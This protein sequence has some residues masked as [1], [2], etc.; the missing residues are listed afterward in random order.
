M[1]SSLRIRKLLISNRGEIACRIIRTARRMNIKTVA[2][3]SSADRNSIHPDLADEAYFIGDPE[4]QKS[5]LNQH[6]IL[7]VARTAHCS[8]IHPGYGFL[9]ENH[10]F[11]SACERDGF[12]FVGPSAQ[13]IKSMGLKSESKQI[14]INAGVPVVPGYHGDGQSN[15]CLMEAAKSIGYPIMLKPVRGGGG[16]G[17]RII[18]SES[19]FIEALESSRRES[20]KSFNDDSMLLERYIVN[21]RHIEVQIFGDKYRNHV[22][23]F[24]RDCSIQRRHQKIIE[25][26]PA[27]MI[28][29]K[30]RQHIGQLAVRAAKAVD[31]VGAGT[32][33]FIMDRDTDELFFMEMNTRLQVE[34]PITEE[35]TNTDLVEWQL[36]VA[37][38]ERLPKNQSEINRSGH[39][40]EA[41]IYAEDPSG[42]FLPEIGTLEHVS[43]PDIDVVSANGRVRVDTG[44]STGAIISP[45][46][47]PMIA[48]L[49][50]WHETRD[51]ALRLLRSC[52][53]RYCIS[54][55]STN[56]EFLSKVAGNHDFELG[57]FGTD[58]LVRHPEI[59]DAY[60]KADN[61]N[62]SDTKHL[63]SREKLP[64]I[65]AAVAKLFES[66]SLEKFC[67]NSFRTIGIPKPVHKLTI[68]E[69][70]LGEFQ[71]SVQLDD[72]QRMM[73]QVVT[74]FNDRKDESS[75]EHVSWWSQDVDRRQLIVELNSERRFK[76]E[77]ILLPG[78]NEALA[79]SI[80]VLVVDKSAN[81]DDPSSR[82]LRFCF[83]FK[84]YMSSDTQSQHQH[85]SS[86]SS[87]SPM[88][89]LVEKILIKVGDRVQ[90][91]QNLILMSAMK[92][93]YPVKSS[94]DG[95]VESIACKVGDFVQ[96]GAELVNI[97][98][99]QNAEDEAA[100]VEQ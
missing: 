18:L 85:S 17:M 33:E 92:M 81:D 62:V 7:Q 76:F 40:F 34:H 63:E 42:D 50:V 98:G 54:G 73:I 21:P 43:H 51:E 80:D 9:S 90:R 79:D 28:S 67:N 19:E 83:K 99:D 96:K 11:C 38:G 48:K 68:N 97:K 60:Q 77:P 88:P 87:L 3:Y 58:F 20:L 94:V 2:V 22:H 100:T 30:L 45:Y 59:S 95:L 1:A 82:P 70:Y 14:M 36:R 91:G 52:L 74:S 12:V 65:C 27:P 32:V 24:E 47:D 49:I 35:I 31:Y 15:D 56:I 89:G 23:L 64:Q 69:K 29:E 13:S 86:G 53:A 37:S 55:V 84:N 26:A 72:S 61:L 10:E 8:A 75:G 25:E 5:Y 66:M 71:V 16:K 46:Y 44:V 93:E 78:L 41:R 4:P 39:A 6:K 57:N